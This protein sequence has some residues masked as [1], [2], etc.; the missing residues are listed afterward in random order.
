MFADAYVTVLV[1]EPVMVGSIAACSAKLYGNPSE[2]VTVLAHS[3]EAAF[4]APNA[5]SLVTAVVE[6]TVDPKVLFDTVR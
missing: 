5:T 4:A 1:V 2:P 6:P 3:T